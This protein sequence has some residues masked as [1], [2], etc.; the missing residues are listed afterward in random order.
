MKDKLLYID[1][2]ALKI[3]AI[4]MVVVAHY[5]RFFEPTSYLRGLKSIGFFGAALFAF[6]SGYL[7]DINNEKVFMGGWLFHKIGSVYLPYVITNLISMFIYKSW[8]FNPLKQVLM[9]SNDGV[10]WYVP[11]IMVF[12]ILFFIVEI[13]EWPR[14]IL[15]S[16]GAMIFIVLEIAGADSQWY[17]SIGALIFGLYA[18]KLKGSKMKSAF[19]NA[20]LFLA[21]SVAAIKLGNNL[22]LKDVLTAI[23]GIGFCGMVFDITMLVPNKEPQNCKTLLSIASGAAYWT[24]LIHMKVGYILQNLMAP[25]LLPF[26]LISVVAA[27]LLNECYLKFKNWLR[28]LYV[29]LR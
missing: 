3:I 25:S 27:I 4:S 26:F 21:S 23:A 24:Y 5:F 1:V 20:V 15:P 17:T 9:G 29:G 10:L 16:M 22:L 13:N 19:L 11:F 12:Y 6:L 18:D 28:C 7:A 2:C 8:A 14:L